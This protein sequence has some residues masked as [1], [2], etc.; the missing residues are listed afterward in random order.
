MRH[1]KLGDSVCGYDETQQELIAAILEKGAL[2]LAADA[3]PPK[4]TARETV[5]SEL[6]ALEMSVTPRRIREAV[7]GVDDGWLK[8]V[9]DNIEQLRE[10][11]K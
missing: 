7:L 2:E 3:W 10:Q 9:N 11:L 4:P 1:F 8:A 6:A 5:L